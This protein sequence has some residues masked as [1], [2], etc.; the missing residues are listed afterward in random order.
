MHLDI[1]RSQADSNNLQGLTPA[2]GKKLP[3]AGL[4]LLFRW[5]TGW[6]NVRGPSHD[7]I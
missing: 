1:V 6:L 7:I 4:L 2:L 3:P 5:L